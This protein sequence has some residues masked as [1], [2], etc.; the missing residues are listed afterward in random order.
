MTIFT[1]TWNTGAY[2]TKEGQVITARF[3]DQ[4]ARAIFNDHSRGIAGVIRSYPPEA[5]AAA[6]WPQSKLGDW[7]MQHYL[8]NL[9]DFD[10]TGEADRLQ[11]VVPARKAPTKRYFSATDGKITVF[12]ASDSRVYQSATKSGWG[13]SFSAK[14]AA[15]GA[16]PAVEITKAEYN[17]LVALKQARVRAGNVGGHHADGGAPSDSWVSNEALS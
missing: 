8:H 14:P 15:L 4:Q 7:L 1:F 13:I 2:Y 11:R 16:M 12:R 6:Q 5:T 10:V 17:A 9:Y 3:D